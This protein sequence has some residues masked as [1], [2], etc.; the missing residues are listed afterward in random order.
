MPK[1]D[2]AGLTGAH[3]PGDRVIALIRELGG[4]AFPYAL[5]II[6][7]AASVAMA[8]CLDVAMP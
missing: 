2:A 1:H 3:P 5:A 6:L 8:Q 4:I 7:I